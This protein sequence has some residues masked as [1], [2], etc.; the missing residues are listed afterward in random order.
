MKETEFATLARSPLFAGLPA[1]EI[2]AVL[3]KAGRRAVFSEGSE[4]VLSDQ[5]VRRLGIVLSGEVLVIGAGGVPLN[6]IGPSGL[7]GAASL[8]G[9]GAGAPTRLTAKKAASILF[10]TEAETEALTSDPRIRRNLLAFLCDRI[11]F[12]NKKVATFSAADAPEK[13]TLYLKERC[14]GGRV[15]VEGGLAQLA[16]TLDLGRASLYRALDRLEQ[17]GTIRRNGRIIEVLSGSSPE[18]IESKAERR[19]P[20]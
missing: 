12:L 4:I 8:F 13:L 14:K 9:E 18:I 10:L 16:R 7:F 20:S 19:N 17:N 2:P 5:T 15:T 11:R 6:R 1:Q 3:G